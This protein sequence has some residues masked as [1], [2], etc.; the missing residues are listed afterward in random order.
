MRTHKQH[1]YKAMTAMTNLY[2][3]PLSGSP[4]VELWLP[5][6][7]F[8][9]SLRKNLGPSEFLARINMSQQGYFG[10]NLVVDF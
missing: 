9:T 10:A 8:S 2:Q 4:F 5:I 3:I 7:N 1:K 6:S